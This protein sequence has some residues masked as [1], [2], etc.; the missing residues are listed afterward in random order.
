EGQL[1]RSGTLLR[2]RRGYELI[3]RAAGMPVVPVWLDRFWGSIF[4]FSGGRYFS[5]WPRQFPYG[6]LVEFGKPLSP[7]EAD[8]A[9]VREELLKLGER[10]YGERPILKHHLGVES[11]RGLKQHPFRTA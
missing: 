11:L 4:S 9:T 8:I 6:V 3:A 2:L 10:A 1:S 5:K 7:N